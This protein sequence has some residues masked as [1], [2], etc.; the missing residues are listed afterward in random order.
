M[1]KITATLTSQD[2]VPPKSTKATGAFELELS[3]D[4]GTSNYKLSLANISNVT[5]VH[6]HQGAKGTN[7]PIIMTLYKDTAHRSGEINGIL[8]EGRIY[9]DQFEGPLA[10]KYISDLMKIIS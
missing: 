2:E 4:G 9:S 1:A 6:M 8:S 7:G 5:L 3:P 10:G